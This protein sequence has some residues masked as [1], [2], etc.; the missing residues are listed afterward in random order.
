MHPVI[1]RRWAN[2]FL[3]LS[4]AELLDLRYGIFIRFIRGCDGCL[5]RLLV[6]L[7]VLIKCSHPQLR[8]CHKLTTKLKR[9]VVLGSTSLDDPPQF[10]TV[11]DF[12]FKFYLIVPLASPYQPWLK[13][14]V[15]LQKLKMLSAA[16]EL[17]I[18][19]LQI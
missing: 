17:S 4:L 15:L 12:N 5:P 8:V 2:G 18:D 16:H 11:I 19:D 6:L 9:E 10:L 1:L 14:S 13:V 3:Y 7:L